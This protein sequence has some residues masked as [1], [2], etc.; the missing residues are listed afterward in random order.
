M[1]ARAAALVVV[2]AC[3]VAAPAAAH[4]SGKVVVR[5]EVVG[6]PSGGN[7]GGGAGTFTLQSG[8]ALDK[9]TDYYS[10]SGSAG[11]ITLTG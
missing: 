2:S 5:I 1:P 6:H 11:N 7:P 10:F 8:A 4:Q 9:G 3:A